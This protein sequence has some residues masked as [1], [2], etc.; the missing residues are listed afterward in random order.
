[1]PPGPP[2]LLP[3]QLAALARQ[4]QASHVSHDQRVVIQPPSEGFH[5]P[6]FNARLRAALFAAQ[7]ASQARVGAVD[8]DR[9]PHRV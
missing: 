5:D 1:M 9:V 3:D 7:A 6:A 4:L 2:G 8:E